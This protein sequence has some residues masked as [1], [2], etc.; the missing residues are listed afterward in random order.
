MS[1]GIVAGAASFEGVDQADPFEAAAGDSPTSG[2]TPTVSLTGLDG[3]ELVFDNVFQG[4]S[5]NAQTL[6]NGPGQTGLW[7]AF[8]SNTRAAASTKQ[9]SGSSVTMSWTAASAAYWAIAAVPINP[10]PLSAASTSQAPLSP[11][12]RDQT[13]TGSAITPALTVTLGADTLVKDTDYTVAYANNTNA[14]TATVTITG[15]GGY[16]GTKGATFTIAEGDAEC[17]HVAECEL[18]HSGPGVVR[19]DAD[20]WSAFGAR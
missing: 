14:G 10:A 12:Y 2:Q 15:I 17:R 1:N 16:S 6:A 8:S 4:G 9:A 19:L 5:D 11:R 18:H 3:D 20:W 13:Y 7:N